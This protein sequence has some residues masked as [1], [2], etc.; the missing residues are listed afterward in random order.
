MAIEA[1]V[2]IGSGI[3][4]NSLSLIVF[5]ADSVIELGRLAC[6]AREHAAGASPGLCGY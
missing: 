4:A 2:A 1:V 5:G 6:C 3:S